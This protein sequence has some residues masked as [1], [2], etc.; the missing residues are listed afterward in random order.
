MFP[1]ISKEILADEWLRINC[2]Q[3]VAELLDTDEDHKTVNPGRSHYTYSVQIKLL[4]F[5][6]YFQSQGLILFQ[7]L[8]SM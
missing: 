8:H 2:A 1:L 4:T 7:N 5:S 3:P 6:H